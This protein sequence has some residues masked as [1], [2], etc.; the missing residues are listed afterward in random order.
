MR[1]YQLNVVRDKLNT[2]QRSS[3]EESLSV[4]WCQTKDAICLLRRREYYADPNM[5]RAGRSRVFYAK[6]GVGYYYLNGKKDWRGKKGGD[7]KAAQREESLTAT[8][9]DSGSEAKNSI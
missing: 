4:T 6:Y 8:I 2:G 5:A 1:E 9:R 3:K 7:F